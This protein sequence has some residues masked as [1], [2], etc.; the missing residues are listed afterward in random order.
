MLFYVSSPGKK[1]PSASS[2]GLGPTLLFDLMTL[3]AKKKDIPSKT[4]TETRFFVQSSA[5]GTHALEKAIR[6]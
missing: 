2:V 1:D 3:S 4:E 5:D 6:S